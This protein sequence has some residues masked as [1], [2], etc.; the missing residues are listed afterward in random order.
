MP[1]TSARSV[2]LP[3][4]GHLASAIALLAYD[5]TANL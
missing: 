3:M 4:P 2:E 5:A 1:K